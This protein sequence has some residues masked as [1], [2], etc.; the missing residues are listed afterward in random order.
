MKHCRNTFEDE[1]R[2]HTFVMDCC[3]PSQGCQQGIIVPVIKEMKTKAVG[4][5]M[6]PSKELSDYLVKIVAHFMNACGCGRAILK[7]DG[8]PSIVA[9]QEAVENVRMS[10]TI[11]EN[12]PKGDSQCNGAAENAVRE[13]E[14]MIRTWKVFVQDK[15]NIVIENKHVLLPWLVSHAGV[16]IT[17]YKKVHDGKTAYQKIKNKSPSNKMMP[18]G[19]KVVWMMPK[20]NHRRNKLG[21]MHQFGVFV[22]IVPRTGEFVVLTPEGAVLVRTVHRLSDDRRWDAEFVSQVRGTPWDFKSSAGEGI[23][24]RVIPERTD[25]LPLDPP[26]DLP[27]RLR[28]RRMYIRRMEVEKYGPTRGCPGC[29]KVMSGAVPSCIA[30]AHNDECRERMEKLMMRD[31]EGAD[32]VVRTKTRINDALARHIE[33]HD[34]RAKKIAKHDHHKPSSGRNQASPSSSSGAVRSPEEQQRDCQD[35]AK[36]NEDDH[37]QIGG[38]IGQENRRSEDDDREAKR[39]RLASVGNIPTEARVDEY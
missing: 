2:L 28:T 25:S 38:K 11:L 24:E 39:Q 18:F 4:A 23:E 15:L 10:D 13:T 26:V 19:E 32:R 16:I 30:A 8:E 37:G 3:F 27:P 35:D 21:P 36:M 20:D 17:R 9:L 34:E 33:E 7:S 22:G 5:F 14:G 31:P 29:E 1:E 6:V 12:P